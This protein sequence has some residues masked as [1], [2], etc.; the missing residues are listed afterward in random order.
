MMMD[1]GCLKKVYFLG[2]GGIGMSSLARWF[3]AS[4]ATVSGYDRAPSPLISQLITEGIDIHF[5]EDIQAI[6]SVPDL[7]IYTPAIH[8]SHAEY[9]FYRSSGVPMMKRAEVLGHIVRPFRTIAISGTHGKTTIST[10]IAHLM[11]QGGR[12]IL[13]FLGGISK[14]YNTNYLSTPDLVKK[15]PF[16][17]CV[18]PEVSGEASHVTCIVE[19]DEYDRSFLHLDPD[20]IVITS[21]DPDHLD[22]YESQ[23]HLVRSFQQFASHIRNDG[24]LIL[25]KG[26]HLKTDFNHSI[27]TFSY[28]WN[29]E[30]DFYARHIRIKDGLTIFDLQTP[31]GSVKELTLGIPGT[32]NLENAVAALA[33]AYLEGIPADTLVRSLRE[34]QGVV[35]RFDFKIRRSDLIYIDDYAH[36]PEELRACIMAV[37]EL[38]PG[39][40]ITGI[41]QPHLYSRTRDLADG[42]AASLSLLDELLLMEIYPAREVPIP[43]ID[44]SIL[45]PK[46]TLKKKKLVTRSQLL[47][48]LI[49]GKY[50]VL[51]TLGAGDIDQMVTPIEA[52]FTKPAVV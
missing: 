17:H 30:A 14:N 44:A 4:G 35:R 32:F 43:G 37:K 20:M 9:Q 27:H 25:K 36:H 52:L 48:E 31:T 6:P 23:D 12:N 42:F 39:K 10:L 5:D 34:F 2:I 18:P 3:A 26:V 33:V 28:S 50:E 40:R 16:I 51:L 46:V 15:Y 19:A 8:E 7:V 24:I 22:I 38:F 21:I 47:R 1:F 45:L 13:A 41:F 29:Q 11:H 49:K